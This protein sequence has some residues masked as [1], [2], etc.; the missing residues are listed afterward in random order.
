MSITIENLTKSFENKIIFKNFSYTFPDKGVFA[1]IGESGVG[2]TTLLR[3]IAGLDKKFSGNIIF[4]GSEA[5]SYA[6]QEY[7]LFP[8]LTGLENVL[9]ANFDTKSEAEIDVCKKALKLLGFSDEDMNLYPVELSGGMKQRISLAR[10]FV[11]SSKILLLDEPTK[12][13][14][15]VNRA[16]VID[17]IIRQ[18]ENKL[19]IMVTHA[20]EEAAALNA[21]V[22]KF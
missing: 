4:R 18:S 2:K 14:D 15:S 9:I 13:L 6:F 5:V 20:P 3:M 11:N 10:A 19:V 7:R 17:E 21:E 16:K 1:L 12:E 22:I 8:M